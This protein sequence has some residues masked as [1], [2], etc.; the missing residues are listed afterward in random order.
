MLT[1]QIIKNINSSK[2]Q[3]IYPLC[4]RTMHTYSVHFHPGLSDFASVTSLRHNRLEVHPIRTL[5]ILAHNFKR[6]YVYIDINVEKTVQCAY[7]VHV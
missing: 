6:I 5:G 7:C 3:A 2:P 4:E 1:P